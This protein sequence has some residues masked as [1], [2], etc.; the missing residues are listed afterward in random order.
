LQHIYNDEREEFEKNFSD[1]KKI[2]DSR[3]FKYEVLI[4]FWLCVH[5]ERFEL[6]QYIMSLDTIVEKVISNIKKSS[7]SVSKLGK[8]KRGAAASS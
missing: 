8:S 3:T 5:L 2:F 4:A 1:V 7:E 6:A